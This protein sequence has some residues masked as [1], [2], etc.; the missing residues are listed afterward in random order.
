[1]LGISNFDEWNK[2]FLLKGFVHQKCEKLDGDLA[3]LN[4][5]NCSR[6]SFLGNQQEITRTVFVHFGLSDSQPGIK[7]KLF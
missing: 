5:A 7:R 3:V 6:E 1:M 2:M 4:Q